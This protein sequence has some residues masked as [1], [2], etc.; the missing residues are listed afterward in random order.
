MMLVC[1]AEGTQL[2]PEESARIG[3]DTAAVAFALPRLRK[4]PVASTGAA[5]A[6]AGAP[7]AAQA[8]PVAALAAAEP[9]GELELAR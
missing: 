3:P 6:A 4:V 1:V 9:E 8:E 2:S 7:A 5:T